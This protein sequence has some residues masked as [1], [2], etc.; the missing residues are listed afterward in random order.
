MDDLLIG[1][2]L[3]GQERFALGEAEG[4]PVAAPEVLDDAAVIESEIIP[5]VFLFGERPALARR[6][7]PG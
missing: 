7:A 3:S 1:V 5:K 6:H 4:P 2:R